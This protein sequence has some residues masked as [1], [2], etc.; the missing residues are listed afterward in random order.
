[1]GRTTPK[2]LSDEIVKAAK[3]LKAIKA[4]NTIATTLSED[5]LAYQLVQAG[6]SPYNKSLVELF[7][8]TNRQWIADKMR[9]APT[10][11]QFNEKLEEYIELTSNTL[12]NLWA[13]PPELVVPAKQV[14]TEPEPEVTVLPAVEGTLNVIRYGAGEEWFDEAYGEGWIWLVCHGLELTPGVLAQYKGPIHLESLTHFDDTGVLTPGAVEDNFTAQGF[15]Q[16]WLN[17][18]NPDSF[19]PDGLKV[20]EELQDVLHLFDPLKSSQTVTPEKKE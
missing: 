13:N 6:F 9:N 5:I 19:T 11:E 14:E 18:D 10:T 2:P 15:K 16:I 12:N 17:Q 20:F 4:F 7:C 3:R 8:T 1:M